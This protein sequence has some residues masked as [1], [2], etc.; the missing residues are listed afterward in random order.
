MGPYLGR[1]GC[2]WIFVQG[3]PEFLGTPQLMGPVYLLSQG[4]F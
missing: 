1:E 3:P 4:W 2:T